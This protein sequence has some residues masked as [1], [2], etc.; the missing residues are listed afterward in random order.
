MN[1]VDI[2]DDFYNSGLHTRNSEEIKYKWP[3]GTFCVL[4][5]NNNSA[6]VAKNTSRTYDDNDN[7][8]FE[9]QHAEIIMLENHLAMHK[10]QDGE[11]KIY[12]N[13][14]PCS[15]CA[16]KLIEFVCDREWRM[17]TAI[18]FVQLYYAKRE[19]CQQNNNTCCKVS[20]GSQNEKGLRQLS[21]YVTLRNFTNTQW[22]ELE[23]L[24]GVHNKGIRSLTQHIQIL[25][26]IPEVKKELSDSLVVN[27]YRE[28]EDMEVAKDYELILDKQ[29]FH[30]FIFD[31]FSNSGHHYMHQDGKIK[32]DLQP[33]FL[34]INEEIVKFGGGKR[35]FVF[36]TEE[37]A[38]GCLQNIFDKPNE[39]LLH[40]T[41]S[42]SAIFIYY[43]VQLAKSNNISF[44]IPFAKLH[45]TCITTCTRQCNSHQNPNEN[46]QAIRKHYGKFVDGVKVKAYNN[47]CMNHLTK[48]LDLANNT[49]EWKCRRDE[50]M[51][52]V[53]EN[54]QPYDQRLLLSFHIERLLREN[55]P[56]KYNNIRQ[57]FNGSSQ[58]PIALDSR[59]LNL[60]EFIN[61]QRKLVQNIHH[62]LEQMSI[63]HGRCIQQCHREF[64]Q[65]F[66]Q[67]N[68]SMFL[69]EIDE[70]GHQLS[71]MRQQVSYQFQQAYQQLYQ[72]H[73]QN[74]QQHSQAFQQHQQRQQLQP[75]HQQRFAQHQQ[76]RH[77]QQQRFQRPPQQ[78]NQQPLALYQNLINQMLP[79]E[80]KLQKVIDLL[81][82]HLSCQKQGLEQH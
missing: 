62:S 12:I 66:Q 79:F 49:A 34:V 21:Q 5:I 30:Q 42:P 16:N 26:Q 72:Q 74:N 73:Q 52:Q 20:E 23:A 22:Q 15:D 56:G 45:D 4:Q 40:M 19:S 77:P 82:H 43:L 28:R 65:F 67:T 7:D 38:I 58:S 33:L 27:K 10:N 47:F 3:R 68:F 64:Q 14:S 75:Q 41:L 35:T 9:G 8:N 32:C 55:F 63:E 44:E 59:M 69:S 24:L 25:E 76:Q 36:K 78:G 53:L 50:M 46:D 48:C 57:F 11:V 13:Y 61:E 29:N 81:H 51:K 1:G 17:K 71:V 60:E 39:I 70:F 18:Y 54:T 37:E 80:N 6:V 31:A 2:F